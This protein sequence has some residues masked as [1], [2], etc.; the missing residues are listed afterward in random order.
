MYQANFL[1]KYIIQTEIIVK[2]I[3]ELKKIIEQ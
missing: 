2:K 3:I 1:L